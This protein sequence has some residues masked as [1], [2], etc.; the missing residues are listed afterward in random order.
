MC[1]WYDF[2]KAIFQISHINYELEAIET[3]DYPTLAQ[4]PH[5]SLLNKQKI[6]DDFQLSIPYWR[7]SLSDYLQNLKEEK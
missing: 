7:D 2:A 3:K 1:S 6:K 4:R 5:Y